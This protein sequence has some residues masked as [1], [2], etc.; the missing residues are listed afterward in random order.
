MLSNINK[1]LNFKNSLLLLTMMFVFFRVVHDVNVFFL[2][3]NTLFGPGF[4]SFFLVLISI[5]LIVDVNF[6][7]YWCL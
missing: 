6:V 1:I 2:V 4:Y 7:N 5:M 3:M